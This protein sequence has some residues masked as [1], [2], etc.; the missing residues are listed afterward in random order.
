[1]TTLSELARVKAIFQQRAI[2]AAL[3]IDSDINVGVKQC[4]I[5]GDSDIIM[6]EASQEGAEVEMSADAALQPSPT[7]T[8]KE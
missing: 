1:M 8:E 6:G 5:C 7:K 2:C 3:G 4:E